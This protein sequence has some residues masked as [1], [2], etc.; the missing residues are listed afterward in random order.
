MR[1]EWL[2]PRSRAYR[3]EAGIFSER[4]ERAS[5]PTAKGKAVRLLGG[6]LGGFW[7]GYWVVFGRVVVRITAGGEADGG[8]LRAVRGAA[9][10]AIERRSGARIRNGKKRGY[11]RGLLVCSF[12]WSGFWYVDGDCVISTPVILN[13]GHI[14]I[15]GLVYT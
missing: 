1:S 8:R 9:P 12:R 6:L 13:G 11:L 14:Y 7:E 5:R 15:L 2:K 4:S 10:R 3:H